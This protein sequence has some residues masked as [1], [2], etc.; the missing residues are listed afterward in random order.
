MPTIKNHKQIL[1]KALNCTA[2]AVGNGMFKVTSCT[3]GNEYDVFVASQNGKVVG[4]TCSCD[5]S[6]YR[7]SEDPRCGCSHAQAAVV[8]FDAQAGYTTVRTWDNKPQMKRQHRKVLDLGDNVC[9]TTR[10]AAVPA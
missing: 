7:P 8:A 1:D 4:A 6:K 9:L 3:S 2:V 10:K 5:W